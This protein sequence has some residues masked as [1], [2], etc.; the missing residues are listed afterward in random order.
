MNS[1]RLSCMQLEQQISHKSRDG[2]EFTATTVTVLHLRT[3]G[4]PDMIISVE[5]KIEAKNKNKIK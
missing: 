3:L 4:A 2:Y 5:D 1:N